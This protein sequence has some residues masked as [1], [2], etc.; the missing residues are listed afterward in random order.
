MVVNTHTG[1]S[2]QEPFFSFSDFVHLIQDQQALDGRYLAANRLVCFFQLSGGDTI[3]GTNLAEQVNEEP[4]AL[5][6]LSINDMWAM[7]IDM[8]GQR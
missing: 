8:A 1:R 3:A 6:T 4:D 7:S 2:L 5:C